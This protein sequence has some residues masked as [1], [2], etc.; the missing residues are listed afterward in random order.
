MDSLTQIALGVAVADK[1]AGRKLGNKAF[2]Y[3]AVLGT[4]PDLDVL[5]GKFMDPIDSIDIHRG[6]SH[7]IVFFLLISPLLAWLIS[8]WERKNHLS[9]STAWHMAFWCLL[10]HVL[11]DAFTSWGTQ[12]FWPLDYR[13]DFKTIFV[14]DPLYTLPLIF[15]IIMAGRFK[16]DDIKR[17]RWTNL[18]LLISTSYLALTVV[19]KFYMLEKFESALLQ[20]NISYR[21]LMVKPSPMNIILWNANVQTENGYYLGDYSLLD[22]SSVSFRFIPKNEHLLTS[23][24]NAPKVRQLQ[25][26]SEGW[27]TVDTTANG[28]LINDLRFGLLH[29]Y[30]NAQENS[31]VFSYQLWEENGTIRADELQNKD[32]ESGKVLLQQLAERIKGR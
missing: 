12:I 3:G 32:R 9:F 2:L 14:V 23:I 4:I 25:R 11:L 17:W 21:N 26:I 31:F 7:S 18:G 29:P 5:A 10:T 13:V 24:A 6:F 15:C 30:S 27:Y 19:T 8:K 20:Q 28:W 22:S 1:I 16:K